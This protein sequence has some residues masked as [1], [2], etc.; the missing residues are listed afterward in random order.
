M[1]NFK[2]GG[3]ELVKIEQTGR[4]TLFLRE[5][6]TFEGREYVIGLDTVYGSQDTVQTC[7]WGQGLYDFTLEEAVEELKKYDY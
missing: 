5:N 6:S 7:S 3:M 4:A 2:N 1:R